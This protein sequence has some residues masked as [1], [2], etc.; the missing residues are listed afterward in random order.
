MLLI[1]ATLL[2]NVHAEFIQMKLHPASFILSTLLFLSTGTFSSEIVSFNLPDDKYELHLIGPGKNNVVQGLAIDYKSNSLYTLHVTGK[3]DHGAINYFELPLTEY[4][5]SVNAQQPS[6]LIGHQ[7]ITVDQRTGWIWSSAG[8]AQDNQ[9]WYIAGFSYQAGNSLSDL[10]TVQVFDEQFRNYGF[11]MPVITA[12]SKHLIV[13]GF[14]DKKFHIRVFD[15]NKIDL[16]DIATID[17]KQKY[18]WL[19][20]SDLVKDHYFL[21]AVASDD[22]YV[23]LFS[24]DAALKNKRLYIYTL[25]GKLVQKSDDIT[26]GKY[27]AMANG[28]EGHW[29]PEGLVYD[30]STNSLLFMFA[31]GDKGKRFATIYRIPVNNH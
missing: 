3:P 1:V 28:T 30:S 17:G 6:L 27:D 9:G 25:D 8:K 23:Y 12:S 13:N 31:M 26:L 24:G 14:K 5:K 29:E 18:E 19:V 10:K 15:L 7:G 2:V 20:D 11:T 4:M 16:N 22:K 21:Q